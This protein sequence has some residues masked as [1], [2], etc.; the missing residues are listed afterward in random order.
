MV[1]PVVRG[2]TVKIG[3]TFKGVN[4]NVLAPTG[5]NLTI[6]FMVAGV[7]RDVTI[8][9]A[10]TGSEFVGQWDTSPADAGTIYWHARTADGEHAAT[11]GKFDIVANPANPRT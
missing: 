4:G 11:E 8:A 2:S 10:Q 5:A 9:M 1:N 6:H 7:K 3:A